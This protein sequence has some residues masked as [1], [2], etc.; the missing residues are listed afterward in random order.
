[1]TPEVVHIHK[2]SHEYPATLRR[3]LGDEA[4]DALWMLGS[5]DLLRQRAVALFCSVKC[6]GDSILKTYDLARGL[7]DKGVTVMGGFHSPMEKECLEL[8][9][10]GKQPII[11]CQAK[12]LSHRRLPDK[13]AGPVRDGRLLMISPFNER[14]SRATTATASIRN[15][16]VAALAD[17]VFV[18]YA[19]PGSKTEVLC[20]KVL[21]WQKS[22]LTF[23][24][25]ENDSLISLGA[26]PCCN[27]DD[28]LRAIENSS[29][30]FAQGGKTEI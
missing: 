23:A 29:G 17:R 30:A 3:Y 11:V 9:L 24:C 25:K 21:K 22:L 2:T 28:V 12:R 26:T 8:L 18:P 1:M 6:P 20:G 7:R 15:E 27:S 16:V 14:V 5:L 13:V 4:P 19:A 10:R